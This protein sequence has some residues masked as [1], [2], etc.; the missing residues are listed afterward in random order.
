MKFGDRIVLPYAISDTFSTM[1]TIEIATLVDLLRRN[2]ARAPF[3][4]RPAAC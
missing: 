2:F 4:E 3:D 1:A